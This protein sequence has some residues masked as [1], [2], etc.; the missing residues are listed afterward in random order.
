MKEIEVELTDEMFLNLAKLAHEL[1]IT[2]NQLCN[3]ILKEKIKK[4]A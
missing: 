4:T 1:D 3:K 2:F